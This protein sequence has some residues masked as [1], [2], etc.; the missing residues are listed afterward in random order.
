MLK[1]KFLVFVPLVLVPIVALACGEDA[2]PT[3]RPTNTP[4]PAPATATPE[5]MEEKP[6]ALPAPP[7]ATPAPT[8]TLAP[9]ETPAPTA[10]SPPPTA[11]PAPKPTA[12][13]IPEPVVPAALGPPTPTAP[14]VQEELEPIYGGILPASVIADIT[15]WDPHVARSNVDASAIS[16]HYMGLLQYDP[17]NPGVVICDLCEEFSISP[18]GKAWTFK[19]RKGIM[20]QDGVETTAE[21]VKFSIDRIVDPSARRP[22]TG[23]IKTYYEST[24]VVDPYTFIL[25]TKAPAAAFSRITGLDFFKV[26]PKHHVEAG[27]DPNV[28]GNI[29]AN[30]PFVPVDYKEAVSFRSEKN[31]NYFRE[32]MP[33][34]DGIKTFILTDPG[35]EIAAYRTERILWGQHNQQGIESLD[36]LSRDDAFL[37]KFDIW[38]LPGTNGIQMIVNT[39]KPPYDNPIVREALNLAIHR[40]PIID[41]LGLGR[42][43]VGKPMSPNNP[44]SLPDE[45]ILARPGFRELNGEKHPDD[46]ARARQLWAE[47]GFGPNNKLKAVVVA[48][49]AKPHPDQGQILKQQLE[50]VLVHVDLEFRNMDLG[51]WFGLVSQEAYDMSSSGLSSATSDPDER[52]AAL[53]L[54]GSRNWARE[55]IEGVKEL[56]EAQSRE[57]DPEK[58]RE[59]NFEMQRLVLDSNPGTMETAWE[60]QAQLVHKKIM[61]KAGRYVP[62][63]AGRSALQHYH[64]WILP[65]TPDRPAFK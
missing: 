28:H 17:L 25:H 30:G 37:K 58:R 11:T 35:T 8:A 48:P 29:L 27:N 50:N 52:F 54:I 63:M 59:I 60:T 49:N 26:L 46:I 23:V 36:R 55:E 61:T 62:G 43:T 1:P 41:N 44:F 31:P 12:T 51:A 45:E 65:E 15:T 22:L 18:D 2:T 6:T 56:F 9:G 39:E 53:Y 40:Q 47:A 38:W 64:E 20:W 19:L 5:A 16:V 10:T 7:T 24:E 57:L 34:L 14:P 42:F 3:P 33:Y 13:P 4:L 32:E 21:D